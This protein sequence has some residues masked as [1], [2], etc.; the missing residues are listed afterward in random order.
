MLSFGLLSNE[1][2]FS[3]VLYGSLGLIV[4]L[5]LVTRIAQVAIAHIRFLSTLNLN[6]DQQRY[7]TL[8]GSFWSKIKKNL[9]VAPLFYRRHNKEFQL[10]TAVNVG[11][12]PSRLHTVFLTFYIFSNVAYCC[13]LDYHHQPR[14]AL[15]AEA[16]G[17]TGHLAVMN[18]LPLFV[19]SA[20]NNP[21]VSLLGISFDTFNLFH[22]WMGRIVILEALA[23]TFIWGVNNYDARGLEGL[24]HHLLTDPFLLYGF[25]STV[26][27]TTVIIQSVSA[28]RHAFYESF[29]HLHQLLAIAAMAGLVLHCEV[30]SL[31]Q[32]PFIYALIALWGL[33]CFIRLCRTF[34][35]RE[36]EVQV[37]ALDGGACRETFNIR[38][39]WSRSPGRHVYAYIPS[40]SLWMSHP[41]SVAWADEARFP[42]D[43]PPTLN[44]ITLRDIEAASPSPSSDTEIDFKT[45]PPRDKNAK[46][47]ISCIVASRTGMTAFLYRKARKSPTGFITMRAFVEGPYVGHENTRRYGTVLLFAGGVGIT[48]QISIARDLVNGFADGTCSTRKAVLIWSVR[49]LEQLERAREWIG[50]LARLPR[51]GCGLKILL[52]VTRSNMPEGDGGGLLEEMGFSEHMAFGRMHVKELIRKEFME[53]VGA[54]GVCGPGGLAD[55]VRAAT[56]DV[57]DVGYV[58]FWEESFTW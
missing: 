48:H 17:R 2:L 52:F 45:L 3:D 56:R 35:R 6:K 7:W 5:V 4:I 49:A 40:V 10:S 53:R 18:M 36:T 1:M 41:F 58:D 14:A 23:H 33:E 11:T 44:G 50:E 37:E 27:M 57:M 26:A 20:R 8:D 22:R 32:K 42:Q 31:P 25:V 51:R 38:G 55:D 43:C 21:F 28:I 12:L 46:T 13:L 47:E 24:T 34:Y 54:M 16:R 30:Q 39:S 29:L 19:F 15:L 9:L